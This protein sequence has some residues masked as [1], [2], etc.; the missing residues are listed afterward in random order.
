MNREQDRFVSGVALG[1]SAS[2]AV[3]GA[4]GS[5]DAGLGLIAFANV[6]L[7]VACLLVFVRLYNN[8]GKKP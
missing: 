8:F 1:G 3:F 5:F 7:F 6:C 4:F 2:G